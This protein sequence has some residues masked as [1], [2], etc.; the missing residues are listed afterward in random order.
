SFTLDRRILPDEDEEKVEADLRHFLRDC[1]ERIPDLTVEIHK[2]SSRKGSVVPEDAPLAQ[3]FLEAIRT[4]RPNAN[5]GM[6]TGFTDMSFYANE[7]AIPCIGYGVAG[8][9]THGI[10]E[11]VSIEDLVTTAKIYAHFLTNWNPRKA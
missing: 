3:G 9:N 8:K 11:C 6:T 7:G 10:D 2:I 5:F 1:A 4:E